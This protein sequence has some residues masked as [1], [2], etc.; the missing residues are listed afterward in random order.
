MNLYKIVIEPVTSFCSPLQSD[1]FFGSFCWS[2]FYKYGEQALQELLFHYKTGNPKIIFSNA[3]PSGMLPMPIG[4]NGSK[5][6]QEKLS[7]KQERY[8]QYILN[9]KKEQL[10]MISLDDFNQILHGNIEISSNFRNE[11]LT[12][13]SWHNIV[14]RKTDN[15]ENLEG[16][17]SLFEVEE[18][19]SSQKYD[20][21]IFSALDKEVLEDILKQ[22]FYFGIGAKRSVGKGAFRI[23]STLEEFNGFKVPANPNGFVA[24]SNFIP[25]K[26]DPT[27]GYYKSFVKYPKVSSISA[28]NDSPFKKPL[29]FFKA[30][31]VFYDQQ[32]KKFYGSCIEKIALKEGKVS[33][34]IVIG[35]YTISVP[36]LINL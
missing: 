8:Q 3:F 13:M 35:A 12:T 2:Y 27:N 14:N 25:G 7:S 24:L 1:T 17:S 4:I 26:K 32:I 15:V 33:D 30:G 29:I 16:N 5:E 19:Y 10:S 28:D 21:Y 23:V 34:E 22:M 31:S 36:C 6:K 9:K 11:E 18:I 20:V